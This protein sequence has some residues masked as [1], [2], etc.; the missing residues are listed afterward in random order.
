MKIPA[1][2]QVIMY[3]PNLLVIIYLKG[4]KQTKSL[5]V[6][7]GFLVLTQFC[8]LCILY[9]GGLYGSVNC[10]SGVLGCSVVVGIGFRVLYKMF[11]G[12]NGGILYF[13]SLLAVYIGIFIYVVV[14]MGYV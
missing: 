2:M 13:N 10:Y 5:T 9:A 3:A 14:W 7:W 1:D 12:G 6:M 8:M 11:F 4:I